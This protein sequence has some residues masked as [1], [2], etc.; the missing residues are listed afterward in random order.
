MLADVCKAGLFDKISLIRKVG[1]K[2][3]EQTSDSIA[4]ELQTYLRLQ[5]AGY[6]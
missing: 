3:K 1:I 5:F 2:F 6:R 4:C